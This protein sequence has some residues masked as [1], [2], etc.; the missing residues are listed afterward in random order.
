MAGSAVLCRQAESLG[1]QVG[2]REK[3]SSR[4]GSGERN[5]ERD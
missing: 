5:R 1:A 3:E 2:E 4:C